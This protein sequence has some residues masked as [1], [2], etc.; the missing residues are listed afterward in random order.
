MELQAWISEKC[1]F[2]TT[3]VKKEAIGKLWILL[4]GQ[5]SKQETIPLHC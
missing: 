2:V 3:I 5:T 4:H 1:S